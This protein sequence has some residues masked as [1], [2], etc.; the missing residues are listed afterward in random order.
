V[1]EIIC[2]S[3]SAPAD[4]HRGD[5]IDSP[6]LYK[7]SLLGAVVCKWALVFMAAVLFDD[8]LC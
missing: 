8:S 1:S 4:A 6:L 5:D 2:A 7:L 3:Q